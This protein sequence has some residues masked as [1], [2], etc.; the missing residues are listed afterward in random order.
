MLPLTVRVNIYQGPHSCY[1]RH[2]GVYIPGSGVSARTVDKFIA[3]ILRDLVRGWTYD[4]SCRKIRMTPALARKRLIYL[5]ALA[6]KHAP[7]DVG[8]VRRRVYEALARLAGARSAVA[9]RVAPARRL[10]GVA[11]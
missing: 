10:A 2:E 9:A 8:Y 5:I 4:H 1:A 7:R 3:Y 11:V 6:K